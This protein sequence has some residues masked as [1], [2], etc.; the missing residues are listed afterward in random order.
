MRLLILSVLIMAVWL[1]LFACDLSGEKLEDLSASSGQ[2]Q[3]DG[4]D[5]DDDDCVDEDDD[6]WCEDADCNDFDKTI[7]PG[8]QE[9]C[10]D[11][12]DNDC[13]FMIDED[14]PDCPDQGAD[15]S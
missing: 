14:D 15:D 10:F 5:E 7:F 13:D 6:G 1:P 8:A 12:T 3:D 4:D 9:D 2:A 11:L